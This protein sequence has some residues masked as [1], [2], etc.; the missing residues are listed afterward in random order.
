MFYTGYSI[1]FD[2]LE[3]NCPKPC[4]KIE[5]KITQMNMVNFPS[6]IFWSDY[7]DNVLKNI[8]DES[9]IK[10]VKEI[11]SRELGKFR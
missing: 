4:E 3:C 11:L 8:K 5:Y 7:E 10:I 1:N 9:Q 2:P 6:R